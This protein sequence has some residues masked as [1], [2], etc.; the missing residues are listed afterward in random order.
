[1]TVEEITNSPMFRIVKK[2]MM[3]K[4]PWVKDIEVD[5]SEPL[6]KYKT[7]YF[8]NVT[9]D[10]H[11]MNEMKNLGGVSSWMDRLGDNRFS[12]LAMFFKDTEEPR[13][14]QLEMEDDIEHIQSNDVTRQFK[15]PRRLAIGEYIYNPKLTPPNKD[16]P[17][18]NKSVDN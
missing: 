2:G 8:V 14:I 3:R 18:D 10:P 16:I 17:T 13:K 11:I 4:Y 12:F 9:I 6:E 1:M 15:L 7:T 5:T